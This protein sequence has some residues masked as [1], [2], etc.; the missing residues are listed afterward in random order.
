GGV[1]VELV[2][3]IGVGRPHVLDIIRNREV[4]LVI[5]T[6]SPDPSVRADEVKI[7]TLSV[8]HGIPVITTVAGANAAVMALFAVKQKPLAVRSLQEFHRDLG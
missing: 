6:P 7:R 4:G 5:N 8:L 2:H 3:K 1:P